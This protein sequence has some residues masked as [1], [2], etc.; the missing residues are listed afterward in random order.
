MERKASGD[1]VAVQEHAFIIATRCR[2]CF[3]LL[4]DVYF[5]RKQQSTSC[6][7]LCWVVYFTTFTTA[8]NIQSNGKSD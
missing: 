7:Q 4:I 3:V 6:T 1:C 5:K 2:G 8:K